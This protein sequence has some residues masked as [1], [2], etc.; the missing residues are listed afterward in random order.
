LDELIER[1]NGLSGLRSKTLDALKESQ[2]TM[3]RKVNSKAN[4]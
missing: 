1:K 3:K 2:T 4:D